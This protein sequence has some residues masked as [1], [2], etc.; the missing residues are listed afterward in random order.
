MSLSGLRSRI[1]FLERQSDGAECEGCAR[2]ALANVGQKDSDCLSC[3]E[4]GNPNPRRVPL[5]VMDELMSDEERVEQ[6][7]QILIAQKRE[8]YAER[9]AKLN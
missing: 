3:P 4:C 8:E 5:W 7:E 2:T 1:K 6:L 9:A